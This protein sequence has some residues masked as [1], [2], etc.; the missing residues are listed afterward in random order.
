MKTT[1]DIRLLATLFTALLAPGCLSATETGDPSGDEL[2]DEN[3]GEQAAGVVNTVSA[4]ARAPK[5]TVSVGSATALQSALTNAK[6]GDHIVLEA[7]AYGKSGGFSLSASGTAA[8]PIVVKSASP[9]AAKLTSELRVTGS[10][11]CVVRLKFD[12]PGAVVRVGGTD[13]KVVGNRFRGWK[14]IAIGVT[15]GARVEIAY[16]ELSDPLPWQDEELDGHPHRNGVRTIHDGV[17]DFHFDGRIHHNYFHDFPT[18]PVPSDYDSGQSDAIEICETRTPGLDSGDYLAGWVLEYNLIERHLQGHGVVDIKCGGVTVRFNTLLSS[19]GG[20]IDI[21]NGPYST[22]AGNWIENSGGMEIYSGYH[23]VLGNRLINTGSGITLAT[24][25]VEWNSSAKTA[26][27]GAQPRQRS[28]DVLLA[29]NDSNKL[30][31]GKSYGDKYPLQPQN[32]VI[33]AHKGPVQKLSQKN[34][35]QKDKTSVVVPVAVKLKPANVGPS[36]LPIQ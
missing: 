1:T 31:I 28:R 33:E 20:R 3:G 7:G 2:D 30:V 26:P 10:R 32:T 11:A 23:D 4:C 34:T 25:S 17:A 12:A 6:P 18:K 22:I 29:G 16:N 14:G 36:A 19:P 35:V 21:R 5:R 24:A 15:D 13:N 27:N 9:L 8:A